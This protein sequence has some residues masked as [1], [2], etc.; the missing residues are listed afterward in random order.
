MKHFEF[1]CYTLHLGSE[2]TVSLCQ[3]KSLIVSPS[4][5]LLYSLI[6]HMQLD[7]ISAL[8]NEN[9]ISTAHISANSNKTFSSELLELTHQNPEFEFSL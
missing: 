7:I 4:L 8:L 5:K 1:V 9:F 2:I 6:F 3:W